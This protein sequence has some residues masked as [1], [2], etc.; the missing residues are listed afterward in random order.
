MGV[1]SLRLRGVGIVAVLGLW[2]L[3]VVPAQAADSLDQSQPFFTG[4]NNLHTPM[5][6]TFTAGGSGAID[7]VSLMVTTVSGASAITVQLQ[8]VAAGKPSGNVLGSSTFVGTVACCHQ[9]KDFT[10]KP[11]VQVTAGTQYAIV[12][13]PTGNLTWYADFGHDDYP[14][15]QLFLASGSSWLSGGS[16]GFDFCF[17]TYLTTGGSSNQPPIVAAASAA[18]TANEGSPVTNSGTFSDPDGDAVT[19]AASAG[20]VTKSGTSSGTWS[21]DTPAADESPA[22]TVTVTADDGHGATAAVTFTYTISAVP[23]TVTIAPASSSAPEGSS[24]TLKGT[25]TSPS[26]ADNVAGLTLT[27]T[28]TKDGNPFATG[29][30]S[31]VTFVPDDEGTFVAT[32]QAVDDGSATA[33]TSVTVIG[34]NVAPLAEIAGLSHD[35]LVLVPMQ[36]ISFTGGFTDPSLLDTHIATVDFGDGTAKD[37]FNF[38]AGAS[39]DTTDTHWYAAPGTYTVTYWVTDDD[40]GTSTVSVKVTV[41][42]AAQALNL[43]DGYVN[44]MASLNSGEK[45]GLS[46]KLDAAMASFARGDTNATCGQLDAFLNDT[47]ALT[48]N[49]RL[50]PVDSATLSSASW[51]VHRALGCSKVKVAWLSLNL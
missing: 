5:A 8:T 32:L 15:G 20:T 49:G 45:S 26:V 19:L 47:V 48:K 28:I 39:A 41:E 38:A 34:T 21:W 35:T 10:F 33:K 31:S 46:A 2:L 1:R 17:E 18:V 27:W 16:F 29:S 43:I 36:P 25:A 42:S 24:V 14:A 4:S 11:G 30:G 12:V 7:R 50:S 13:R 44:S 6:Q 9:W 40:G 23:P 51:E 22:T 3:T 37:T